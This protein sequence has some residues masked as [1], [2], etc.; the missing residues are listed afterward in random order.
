[1]KSTFNDIPV[2]QLVRQRYSC[3]TYRDQPL[4]AEHRNAL[5]EYVQ[6]L[7]IGPF[8]GTPRFQLVAARESDSSALKNLGTYGFIRGAQGYLV[9]AM[10]DYAYNHEDYGYLMELIILFATGKG[11]GTCWLG[12]TFTKSSFGKAI[13]VQEDELVPAVTAL[14]YPAKKPRW[15]ESLIRGGAGADNRLPWGNLFT[16]AHSQELSPESTG[17]YEDVLEMVRWAPSASNKQPW[18]I[19][20][21]ADSWHFFLQRTPGYGE[22][23]L[24]K[25]FTVADMQRLDMGIAM[26]HFELAARELDLAGRWVVEDP[27][28]TELDAVNTHIVS[29]VDDNRGKRSTSAG[30]VD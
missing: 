7:P 24:N 18:R 22:R 28:L 21:E 2:S 9:G 19:V 12:G 26:C 23:R 14:G 25:K 27:G 17:A 3:R 16:D 20:K 1:M 8:G 11:L 4:T 29:W 13:A 15:V 30:A 6:E 10:Q 5:N